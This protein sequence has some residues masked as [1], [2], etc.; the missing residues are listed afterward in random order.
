MSAPAAVLESRPQAV[1]RDLV[2]LRR[3][4]DEAVP[5]KRLDRN[6]LIATWN[7]RAF[8]DLTE[9]WQAG[10][11]DSPKRDLHA[12]ACITEIVS[13]FDVVALQEV[14]GNIKALRHMLRH[15][16][17]H[18]GL[19]LTD[20]TA[21]RA[22][23]DERM[24]F[25]FDTR[26][27][28]PSGLACEL[29]IPPEWHG[30]ID[31]GALARQFARTPY[32]ASFLAGDQTFILVTLHVVYGKQATDRV[33]EL[34][35]IAEWMA[36]WARREADWGHNLIALGDFNI[37]RSGDPNY[38][39][40]T[41]TGLQPP[42]QLDQV[43][44][45]IFDRDGGGA[46]YDQIAWFRGEGGVP[47]LSLDYTGNAGGFDFTRARLGQLEGLTLGEVSWRISDHLPLWAE[48]ATKPR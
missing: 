10:P 44:R 45:T 19:L 26:R 29:V 13:R 20:V 1:E 15:L 42:G 31:T 3:S 4:L 6:L 28:K 23:N 46:F 2:Q 25:V 43:P 16:G 8:G 48:F 38:E 12:L 33:G 5:G 22:G 27:V 36:S 34:R 35:W 18:W 37:D 7:I 41:A 9:R 14:R 21:G 17:P 32:A 30:K 11:D 24:A 47:M 39:A 40:F